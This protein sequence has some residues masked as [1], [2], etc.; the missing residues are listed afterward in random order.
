MWAHID[1]IRL[2]DSHADNQRP[3][4]ADRNGELLTEFQPQ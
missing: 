2:V 1:R 3:L 4:I